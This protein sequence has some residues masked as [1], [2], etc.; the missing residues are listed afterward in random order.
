[1]SCV[2]R[3][4]TS[5]PKTHLPF[6]T[7]GF[8]TSKNLMSLLKRILWSSSWSQ[9]RMISRGSYII[10][11]CESRSLICK[12]NWKMA[13]LPVRVILYFVVTSMQFQARHWICQTQSIIVHIEQPWQS[14]LHLWI[15]TI[16]GG[17]NTPLHLH[18]IFFSLH[19]FRN[20]CFFNWQVLV[21]E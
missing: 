6:P 15:F 20:H 14:L 10:L 17:A 12:N 1:M 13:C 7:G 4:L 18:S 21:A 8:R 16:C 11:V 19:V 2:F 3:R 5:D 9:K